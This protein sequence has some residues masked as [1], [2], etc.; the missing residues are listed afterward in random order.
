[1]NTTKVR[2]LCCREIQ[3]SIQDSSYQLLLDTIDRLDLSSQFEITKTRI[4][5]IF[6]GSYVIFEGLK[7]NTTKIKSMNG[8][9]LCWVEEAEA[10]TEESW[11]ILIPTIRANNSE[12]WITFNP[13]FTVDSTWLMFVENPPEDA[14]VVK[15]N[16]NDNPAFPKELEKERLHLYN[17]CTTSGNMAKYNNIWLGEPIGEEFNTL[18]TP[19]NIKASQ[20]RVLT[21][22]DFETVAGLDVARYGGD[23]SYI[24]F[25]KGNQI[26]YKE[27]LPKGGTL[28]VANWAIEL[29][30]THQAQYV[31]VDAAGSAGVF[32]VIKSRLRNEMKC[33]EF[34]GA[35]GASS[36]E[37]SNCRTESWCRMEEWVSTTGV[38]PRDS[39][40]NQ[41]S[42]VTYSFRN[43]NQ[44]FLMSKEQMRLKGIKSPDFGDALSMT[45]MVDAKRKGERKKLNLKP[46]AF[47]G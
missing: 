8:I 5:H 45:F 33:V 13:R 20:D 22:L 39:I 37:F 18:I 46:S 36:D 10:V 27:A 15:M 44:K 1:M 29:L 32:D 24:V 16:Y 35:F 25:R 42:V 3:K 41:L 9:D 17:K 28:D 2:V 43:K 34:N 6:T 12:I 47:R 30:I 23:D 14:V 38:L 4:T 40:V 7:A 11:E 21:L 19:F 31:V 26:I